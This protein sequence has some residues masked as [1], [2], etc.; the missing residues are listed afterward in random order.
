MIHWSNLF[1]FLK[2]VKNAQTKQNSDPIMAKCHKIAVF[3]PFITYFQYYIVIL[4][5]LKIL[6][7]CVI[8]MC[9]T[10]HLT[11]QKKK[12]H[13][14]TNKN[15][16]RMRSTKKKQN[17]STHFM[18]DITLFQTDVCILILKSSVVRL[19]YTQLVLSCKNVNKQPHTPNRTQFLWSVRL[20]FLAHTI[21]TPEG[22]L[23][24]SCWFFSTFFG[25]V[26]HFSC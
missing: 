8:D 17:Q 24:F 11:I 26:F 13:M 21:K 1:L 16:N 22:Q 2:I 12:L 10:F 5:H 9:Y 23:Y 20:R 3:N 14:W 25:L 15:I 6:R 4:I 7:N 18:I 19:S